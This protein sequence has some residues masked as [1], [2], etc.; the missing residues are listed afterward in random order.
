ME[1]LG[2]VGLQH[3]GHFPRNAMN[4]VDPQ[5][6]PKAQQIPA[7]RT[8]NDRLDSFLLEDPQPFRTAH[9]G[10]GDFL[11]LEWLVWHIRVDADR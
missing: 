11:A 10:Q 3:L 4:D 7:Q 8:A 1:A 6:F 2:A 5:P 9:I